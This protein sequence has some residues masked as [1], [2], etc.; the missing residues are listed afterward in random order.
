[1]TSRWGIIVDLAAIAAA[2]A[3]AI[4]RVIPES[5]TASVI[6]MVIAGRF[7]PPSDGDGGSVT[8]QSPPTGKTSPPPAA[9]G[10]VIALM[11]L[12]SLAAL[13]R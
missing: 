8:P 4:L 5:V 9:S 3:L 12:R 7:R 10:F 11:A 1:M 6:T 2:T 13:R